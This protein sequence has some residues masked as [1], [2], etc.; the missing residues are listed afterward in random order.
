MSWYENYKLVE[1][2]DGY[3]LEI[4]LNPEDTEF[5]GEF[6][7][8]IKENVLDL[9]ERIKKFVGDNFKDIKITAVKL[10]LGA[11]V[12][13]AIP[14]IHTAKAAAEVVNTPTLPSQ[15]STQSTS[16]SIVNT[17]GTVTASS[18]NV[19]TG[20]ATTFSIIL[21]LPRGS[22]IHIIGQQ[23][24]WYRVELTDGRIGWVKSAYL[25]LLPP[26]LEQKA[27]FVVAEAESLIGTPY[28]WGGESL[29]E[30]GFDCSGF[31]QYVFKQAGYDLLRISR[32]QSTQGS[33][34][35]KD[36]L[37]PGDLVFFSLAGDGRI[38]HVGI[39]IGD[40]RMIHSPKTGDFVKI[41]NINT[42][43]WQGHFI[44]ARRIIQ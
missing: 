41:A 31:T 3:V 35:D 22:N 5:S 26:T 10:M 16:I 42:S 24:D 17:T 8:D 36:S 18:L 30:G 19:R 6:F 7:S 21:K 29:T 9:D 28:V 11:T 1:S 38:S 25:Q 34:V 13:G 12:V 33:L 43:F 23:Q 39:Y 4:Y 27:D 15:T 2:G 32:D 44:T 20:P 37:K 14:F 40:G